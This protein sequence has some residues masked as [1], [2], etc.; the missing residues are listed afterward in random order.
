MV[1][2]RGGDKESRRLETPPTSEIG[3]FHQNL[4]N[5]L[6]DQYPPSQHKLAFFISIFSLAKS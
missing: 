3:L 1:N 2:G 6:I 5:R 4:T